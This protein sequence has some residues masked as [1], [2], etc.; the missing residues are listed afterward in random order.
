MTKRTGKANASRIFAGLAQI[1]YDPVT[2]ILD[3]ADNGVSADATKIWIDIEVEQT[4][5]GKRKRTVVNSFS[6][7]DNGKGMNEAGIENA[8]AFGSSSEHYTQGTLSKFGL[9]LKSASGALGQALRIISRGDDGI[10]RTAFLDRRTLG[11]AYEFDLDD[12]TAIECERF[13]KRIGS[14]STGTIIEIEGI[15]ENLERPANIIRDLQQKAGVVYFFFIEGQSPVSRKIKFWLNGKKIVSFDPLFVTEANVSLDDRDWDGVSVARLCTTTTV[16]LSSSDDSIIGTVEATQLPHPPTLAKMDESISQS[17]V[18]RKYMIGAG[19]Y[20]FY[21]YRNGRLISWADNLGGLIINDQDLYSIRGRL[22]IDDR[23]DEP[24]NLD[25]TKSR[26][27]LSEVAHHELREVLQEPISASRN[28]W[29]TRAGKLNDLLGTDAHTRIGDELVDVEANNRK[30]DE[31]DSSAQSED[32]R[33]KEKV[34][35]KKVNA[36]PNSDLTD[37]SETDVGGSEVVGL[38]SVL[39]DGQLWERSWD[40]DIG[41]KVRVNEAHSFYRELVLPHSDNEAVV[42]VFETL[43]YALA[44]GEY[45]S[46]RGLDDDVERLN[47]IMSEFRSQVGTVLSQAAKELRRQKK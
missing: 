42:R 12:A 3:I 20:G 1:G 24:L 10:V 7:A 36:K 2:A 4:K 26:I 16:K 41:V 44:R 40:A 39:D 6:I 27:Q 21:V 14:E 30:Q 23:A 38:V 45:N 19:N 9:G 18:R 29:K 34:R 11:A 35:T 32:E 47:E 33:K 37:D 43:M 46:V 31:I 25:V 13:N 22:L 28:A 17:E 8:L 5:V 15:S